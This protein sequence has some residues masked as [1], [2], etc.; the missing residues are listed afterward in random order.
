VIVVAHTPVLLNLCRIGQAK[1]LSSL[2]REVVVP[3]EVAADFQ[4]QVTETPRFEGMSLPPWVRQQAASVIPNLVRCARG[5][6]PAAVAA[7][8]LAAEIGAN[9][10]LDVPQRLVHLFELGHE[11]RECGV[12]IDLACRALKDVKF[13]LD[14]GSCF[15]RREFLPFDFQNGDLVH[16]FAPRD[17]HRGIVDRLRGGADF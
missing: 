17:R 12:R 7:L 2:F 16:Q 14:V 10:I 11:G 5:L 3:P 13:S 15:D 1:L 4:R 6:D 9:A 8:A